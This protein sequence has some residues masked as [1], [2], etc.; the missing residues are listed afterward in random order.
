MLILSARA[1]LHSAWGLLAPG[2]H[3]NEPTI[4]CPCRRHAAC[5]TAAIFSILPIF[6]SDRFDS[7]NL[8]ASLKHVKGFK[9]KLLGTE[10]SGATRWVV[11]L[12]VMGLVVAVQIVQV[13]L[14]DVTQASAKFAATSSCSC[15][16][17]PGAPP[18]DA[19]TLLDLMQIDAA[20]RLAA[21][22]LN[23][24]GISSA[25]TGAS[26]AGMYNLPGAPSKVALLFLT[27]GDLPHEPLWRSFLASASTAVNAAAAG[28]A[29]TEAGPGG[30][31]SSGGVAGLGSS[32]QALF[33]I[34]T[35]P[36]PG[37]SHPPGSL[38]AGHE[39]PGRA[40]VAWGNHRCFFLFFFFNLS[41]PMRHAS[42]PLPLHAPITAPQAT[43][44]KPCRSMV[45]A[46]RAL[47]RAALQDPA[48]QRFVLLSETCIPLHPAP[49]VYLQLVTEPV[50][51]I[52][53]S[54]WGP[55]THGAWAGRAPFIPAAAPGAR[56]PAPHA[57]AHPRCTPHAPHNARPIAA[58]AGTPRTLATAPIVT[59]TAG[60]RAC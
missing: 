39:V 44:P 30:A 5:G 24:A 38:F 6:C 48:N 19:I 42:L 40:T 59:S 11:C 28:A 1:P 29:R 10:T 43:V 57:A 35:H 14:K 2:R 41:V 49:L 25:A 9:M 7:V 18:P 56:A 52:D 55:R 51:R 45:D 16:C 13:L 53:T 50:S 47:L 20:R 54:R 21:S 60:A 34:Y 23:A 17:C 8:H 31:G 46:E 26:D 37:H 3:L 32:W 15:S 12:L 36:P 22:G 33:T 27:R 58:A 4:G